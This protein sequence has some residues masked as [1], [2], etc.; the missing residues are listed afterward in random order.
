MQILIID[1]EPVI[2]Q[3]IRRFAEP[4]GHA[5]SFLTPEDA[6]EDFQPGKYDIAII[7][8]GLPDIP[9]NVLAERLKQADPDLPCICITGYPLSASDPEVAIFE[10]VVQKPFGLGLVDVI[11]RFARNREDAV[12]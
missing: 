8:I 2:L 5:T 4:I 7:D 12:D 1:D 6:L 11:K 3:I 10:E 9:G